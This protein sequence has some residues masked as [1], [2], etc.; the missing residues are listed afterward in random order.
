MYIK[1]PDYYYVASTS[2]VFRGIASSGVFFASPG[3]C[4]FDV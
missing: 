3:E 4:L 1:K 2:L